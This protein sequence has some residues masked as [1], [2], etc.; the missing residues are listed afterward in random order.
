[1]EVFRERTRHL[2]KQDDG[3]EKKEGSNASGSGEGNS[4]TGGSDPDPD[5]AAITHENGAGDKDKDK[6]EEEEKETD[7]LLSKDEEITLYPDGAPE[8]F[9]QKRVEKLFENW[10]TK[11]T[12][13]YLKAYEEFAGMYPRVAS[14]K[15][16][17][18]WVS[19]SV[20]KKNVLKKVTS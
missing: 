10:S 3:K 2:C 11:D 9:G 6:D 7:P 19:D 18:P 4:D 1:M 8:Q 13:H 5:P 17:K 15:P 16:W 12:W 20:E 14:G